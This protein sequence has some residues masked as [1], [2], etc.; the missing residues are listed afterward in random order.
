MKTQRRPI[1]A[2]ATNPLRAIER[3]VSG[4]TLRKSA[5]SFKSSVVISF[6]H[7]KAPQSFEYGALWFIK[8]Y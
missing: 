3:I 5:A 7:K 2:P 1:L 8:S 6:S 4:C